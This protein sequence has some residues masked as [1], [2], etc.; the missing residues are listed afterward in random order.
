MAQIVVRQPYPYDCHR[1]YEK[2][3]WSCPP[4]FYWNDLLKRC[5]IQP[6]GGCSN[7]DTST[8][9]GSPPVTEASSLPAIC[10][11]KLGQLIAYP[12]DC[13][14]FIHCDYLPFVKT[15]PQYLF[16]NSRLLTCDKICV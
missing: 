1:Y 11:N 10:D 12:G 9:S 3:L 15:C 13:T 7:I 2:A 14:R 4:N 6:V 5:E 8:D 16:W